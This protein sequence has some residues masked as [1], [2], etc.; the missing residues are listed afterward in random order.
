VVLDDGKA[1][2]V[3]QGLAEPMGDFDEEADSGV[4]AA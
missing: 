4:R 2:D 1:T 3:P